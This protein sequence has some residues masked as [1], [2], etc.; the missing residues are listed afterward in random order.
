[1][2]EDRQSWNVEKMNEGTKG[3]WMIGWWES[4]TRWRAQKDWGGTCTGEVGGLGEQKGI[5]CCIMMCVN[6][7]GR[8]AT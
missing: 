1:M 2:T 5:V 3:L 4:R 6:F 8:W 7:H